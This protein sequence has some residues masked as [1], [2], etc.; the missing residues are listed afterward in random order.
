VIKHRL[1]GSNGQ[2]EVLCVSA[3]NFLL[4]LPFSTVKFSKFD[5][6]VG[7]LTFLNFECQ[8]LIVEILL[9]RLCSC[10]KQLN[11]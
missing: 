10:V 9:G 3:V 4:T 5:Q 7:P 8:A 2:W 6:K 11:C 1:I